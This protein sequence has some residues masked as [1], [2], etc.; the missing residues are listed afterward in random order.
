MRSTS[1]L[2]RARRSLDA[3]LSGTRVPAL[4]PSGWAKAVRQA[5]GLSQA[6]AARRLGVTP[7]SLA[8]LERS[9]ADGSIRLD[10]LRRLA[11]ALGCD[12]AY[13]FVPRHPGGLEGAVQDRARLVA[14]AELAP[15]RHTMAL[16]AQ[17]L[18]PGLDQ[19]MLAELAAEVAGSPRRLW[20]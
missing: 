1:M 20:G 10:S 15:V 4:P 14:A 2:R 13:A 8:G 9:E 19:Q 18:P 16:E 5:L 3:E 12:L 17:S 11:D 7:Q 6:V